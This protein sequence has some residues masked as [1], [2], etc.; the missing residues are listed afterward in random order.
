MPEE[1][2]RPLKK[3]PSFD[4]LAVDGLGNILCWIK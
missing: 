4:A 3:D 2:C 1:I